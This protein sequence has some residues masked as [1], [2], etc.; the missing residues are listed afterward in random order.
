MQKYIIIGI[1]IE[2][3]FKIDEYLSIAFN[4]G[5]LM[6]KIKRVQE[7]FGG[8]IL[9]IDKYYKLDNLSFFSFFLLGHLVY[10]FFIFL[11]GQP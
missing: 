10:L 3:S 4:Y 6:D 7:S 11:F 1:Q 5:Y 2:L 8:D 9:K